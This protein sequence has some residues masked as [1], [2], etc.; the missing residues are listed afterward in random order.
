VTDLRSW[1]L[2][3]DNCGYDLTKYKS[4]AKICSNLFITEPK[5]CTNM[6]R[7]TYS[8]TNTA[9]A[10]HG[11]G[12]KLSEH[13][14]S[15]ITS[16]VSIKTSARDSR[17]IPSICRI[18]ACIT[19]QQGALIR[20]FLVKSQALQLLRDIA[21]NGQIAVVFSQPSSHKTLQ[22]KGIH[23]HQTAV[24][25]TDLAVIEA[26]CK[27]FADSL[28]LLGVDSLSPAYGRTCTSKNA[29]M[30]GAHKGPLL[31]AQHKATLFRRWILYITI[32]MFSAISHVRSG[33][34]AGSLLFTASAAESGH[35]ERCE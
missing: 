17:L 24:L 35:H 5:N 19:Q 4:C 6:T 31:G 21:A 10:E 2:L 14:N 12:L 8:S 26:C 11:S 28:F 27:G 22:I 29:P 33:K 30:L 32:L 16:G 15:F 25:D 7:F 13:M 9:A 23:A 20:L 18:L 34:A 1:L 3:V